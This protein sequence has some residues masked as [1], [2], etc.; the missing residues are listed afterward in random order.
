MGQFAPNTQQPPART[1]EPQGR[2]QFVPEQPRSSQQFQPRP[3][4]GVFDQIR[5]AISSGTRFSPQQVSFPQR[6]HPAPAPS[7]PASIPPPDFRPLDTVPPGSEQIE[8]H[9][10]LE[11]TV[12]SQESSEKQVILEEVM[13]KLKDEM[14]E[15]IKK[16]FNS[17]SEK[18]VSVKDNGEKDNTEEQQKKGSN[19]ERATIVKELNKILEVL[20]KPSSIINKNKKK[21][22]TSLIKIQEKL[23]G[24]SQLNT[25]NDS[26]ERENQ[27]EELSELL[28]LLSIKSKNKP[29]EKPKSSLSSLQ[30]KILKLSGKEPETF[31]KDEKT[32]VETFEERVEDDL[33]AVDEALSKLLGPKPSENS[34]LSPEVFS[35]VIK[36][37]DFL[38]EEE[39]EKEKKVAKVEN[40]VDS[41]LEFIEGAVTRRENAEKRLIDGEPVFDYDG[42]YGELLDSLD[43]SPARLRKLLQS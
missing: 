42:Y 43:L 26:A 30:E 12:R 10:A 3:H 21:S 33:S 8:T 14:L 25:E 11:E 2:Q 16:D 7:A 41:A 29:K 17:T 1:W 35:V 24:L 23:L 13:R 28:N 20:S 32:S 31:Q 34:K 19:N 18:S 9:R 37:D 6:Q 38:K 4:V 5:T 22:E 15:D 39:R 27:P 36:L 40:L